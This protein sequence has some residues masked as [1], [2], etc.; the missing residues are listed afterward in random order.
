MF[1][2]FGGWGKLTRKLWP[3]AANTKSQTF[4][5][6]PCALGAGASAVC[7]GLNFL[8]LFI[9]KII[10]SHADLFEQCLYFNMKIKK[11]CLLEDTV[12]G[13][14]LFMQV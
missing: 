3:C 10:M 4:N 7:V 12:F 11:P 5:S 9:F 6:Q 1:K 8:K 2:E 14:L 13:V